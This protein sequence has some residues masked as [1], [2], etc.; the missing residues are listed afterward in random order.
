MQSAKDDQAET[1]N[2]EVAE[3]KTLRSKEIRWLSFLCESS[4]ISAFLSC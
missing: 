1:L 4:A 2:A 3:E